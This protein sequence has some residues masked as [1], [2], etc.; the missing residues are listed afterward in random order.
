MS[1]VFVSGGTAGN[2]TAMTVARETWRERHGRNRITGVACAPSAHSS[3][4]LAAKVIDAPVVV[5]EADDR[6]R[7]TGERLAEAL[8]SAD[9][10]V[11]AAI[12]TGGATNTGVVDDLDGIA[13]VCHERGVW[14]QS[15]PRTAVLVP[16]VHKGMRR[17][18]A[19]ASS[20][21][22]RRRKTSNSLLDAM[23]RSQSARF[24]TRAEEGQ[25]VGRLAAHRSS[26]RAPVFTSS[27]PS[28]IP[29]RCLAAANSASW[30]S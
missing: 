15:T 3:I 17:C 24:E 14:M 7:L 26:F 28:V 16:T 27:S 21:H 5:V 22:S 25:H 23:H 13:T 19:S 11:F 18:S 20:T 30:L 8:A 2:L 29:N 9:V 4:G 6:G 12:A 10:A 1:R